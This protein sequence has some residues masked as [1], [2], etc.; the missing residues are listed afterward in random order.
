MAQITATRV[1]FQI[2]ADG[3]ARWL[4]PG[5]AVQQGSL[6]EL[7]RC[8]ASEWLWLLDG[9]RV[10]VAEV[11]VPAAR[12]A[13]QLQALPFVLEDQ[14]LGALDELAI[15]HRR[16]GRTTFMVALSDRALLLTD[17]ARLREAGIRPSACV[18]ELSAVPCR[19][20]E[21]TL[22]TIGERGWLCCAAHGS[23]SFPASEWSAFVE[24]ALARGPLPA[25]VRVLGEA[26]TPAQL[27][28]LNPT[29]ATV[30]EPAP[31][32]PLA[33]FAAG[34]QANAAPDFL[35]L[36][37][38]EETGTGPREQ[39]LFR[40]AAGLLLAIA[41]GHASFLRWQISTLEAAVVT[42]KASTEQRFREI[43]P[44]VPR[45]VDARVQATQALAELAA[46]AGGG[47]AFTRL[48]AVAG[49][50]LI[51][52]DAQGLSLLSLGFEGDALELRVA[53]PDIAT[54]E[55]YQQQLREGPVPVVTLSVE[56]RSDSTEAALRLGQTP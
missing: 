6:A 21:W 15:A 55:R 56:R 11:E 13:V 48:L 46:S 9:R 12:A 23:F 18:A 47:G 8:G 26:V 10:Q 25:R 4:R 5:S 33:L 37:P 49:E 51:A 27:S 45:V 36:L 52:P 29:I 38:C 35:S 7:A 53:A 41:L 3:V 34:Y 19:P 50:P 14:L 22:A 32:D 16:L 44:A 28:A 24:T 40:A 1:F 43:F 54:I 20:D 39:R 42:A 17:H 31:A 30:Q 2:H